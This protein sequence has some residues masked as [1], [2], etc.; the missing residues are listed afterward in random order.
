MIIFFAICWL[1]FSNTSRYGNLVN[2]SQ[3]CPSTN[4]SAVNFCFLRGSE[5][6]DKKLQGKAH[7]VNTK[8]L[9]PQRAGEQINWIHLWMGLKGEKM[10]ISAE[11]SETGRVSHQVI[12]KSRKKLIEWKCRKCWWWRTCLGKFLM[13]VDSK[14]C[15]MEFYLGVRWE[16][17]TKFSRGRDPSFCQQPSDSHFVTK[18]GGKIFK[19]NFILG[20]LIFKRL[21]AKL[22]SY[23]KKTFANKFILWNI[24][25][26]DPFMC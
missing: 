16:V 4:H 2:S 22:L 24:H 21:K 23:K 25:Q 17:V 11:Y 7:V 14:K 12:R 20:Q 6:D 19:T 10:R 13:D 26:C 8:F 3:W 9:L 5:W 15:S 18:K 1:K